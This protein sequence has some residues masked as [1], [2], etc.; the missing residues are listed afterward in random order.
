MFNPWHHFTPKGKCLV[1][2]ADQDRVLEFNAQADPYHRIHTDLL[3]EPYVGSPDAEIV[4]LNL[5]PGC[6][7]KAGERDEP[8]RLRKA[9]GKNLLHRETEYPFYPLDPDLQDTSIARWWRG[10]LGDLLEEFDASLIAKHLFCV[11][12]APYH[13]H[14]YKT[15]GN[16]RLLSQRYNFQ[17]VREC[18]KHGSVVIAMRHAESWLEEVPKLERYERFF[19]AKN[20]QAKKLSRGNLGRGFE[21]IR[22]T[23]RALAK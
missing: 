15:L 2:P 18:I 3:P 6:S 10:A 23:L 20:P 12:F 11:E 19:I 7:L 14:K 1:L 8:K 17:L 9:W 16:P 21:A 22:E 13:S 5:N 4:L